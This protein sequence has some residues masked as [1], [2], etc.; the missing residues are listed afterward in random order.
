MQVY[1]D[2]HDEEYTTIQ[3]LIRRV[4]NKVNGVGFGAAELD[5]PTR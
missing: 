3:K 1:S 4:S 5:R 2:V